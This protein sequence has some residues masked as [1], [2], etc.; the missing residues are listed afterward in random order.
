MHLY[1]RLQGKTGNE[2]DS[3]PA[4]RKNCALCPVA[5]VKNPGRFQ[6][7]FRTMLAGGS[8]AVLL[9]L[10]PGVDPVSQD[11]H[12]QCSSPE[13]LVMERSDV[14]LRTQG[15]LCLIPQ[16]EDGQLP[17]LV[18]QCLPR[19]HDVTVGFALDFGLRGVRVVME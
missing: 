10:D 6:P 11:V 7:G 13:Y 9:L 1:T 8:A 4:F 12:R 16:L 17:D 14:E 3:L 2:L 5:G 15:L 19:P 18:S